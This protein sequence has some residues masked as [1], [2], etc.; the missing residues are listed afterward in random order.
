LQALYELRFEQ[1]G[2][3]NDKKALLQEANKLGIDSAKETLAGDWGKEI[4]LKQRAQWAEIGI[5]SV[6][7]FVFM[8]SG[9][10]RILPASSQTSP[11]QWKSII[12]SL[13]EE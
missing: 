12:E 10:R 9:K 4:V 11:T 5:T 8:S 3:L 1:G 2:F 7:Q 6:P 13:F